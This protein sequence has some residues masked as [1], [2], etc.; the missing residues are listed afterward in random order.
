MPQDIFQVDSFTSTLFK[1]NPAAVCILQEPADETWMQAV[2]REM[3]LSETAFVVDQGDHY[4]LRWFTPAVEVD[5]CG[6][7][8]LATAHIIWETGLA[9]RGQPLEFQTRSGLLTAT[10]KAPRIVLNF[11]SL[12]PQPVQPPAELLEGLNTEAEFVGKNRD[13]YIVLLASEERVRALEPNFF[14][15]KSLATRGV[16]VTSQA[17][18]EEFDFVSR[19]FAPDCGVDEDPVTGSS[20]T[21]LGPFWAERFGK[22]DLLAYQASARGGVVSVHVAGDRVEIGGEAVT[23]FKAQLL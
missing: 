12:P 4:G 19:F 14:I 11:P 15:L 16:M 9:D 5:L 10:W 18:S 21:C 3:N 7:A 22:N 23:V 20:F 6:H 17:D 13:D 2:S 1:G 8:T